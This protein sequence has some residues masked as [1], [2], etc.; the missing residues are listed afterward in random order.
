MFANVFKYFQVFLNVSEACCKC[1]FQM[2]CFQTYIASILSEC[3]I[4]CSGY[5]HMLHAY[6]PNIS[7]VLDIC[8][9]KSS[10][11]QVFHEAQTVPRAQ[12]VPTGRVSVGGAAGR[13][14]AGA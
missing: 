10:M 14:D 5:T 3:C 11:L 9:S 12:V 4:C 8:C 13:A 1:V 7:F 2:F 6:V